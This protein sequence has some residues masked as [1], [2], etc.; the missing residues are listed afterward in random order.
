[1]LFDEDSQQD[2]EE[3]ED[4][5]KKFSEAKKTEHQK[6]FLKKQS[7]KLTKSTRTGQNIIDY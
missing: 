6:E 5:L 2:S 3:A 1:M 7:K 4:Y